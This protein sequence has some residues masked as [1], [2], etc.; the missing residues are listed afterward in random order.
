MNATHITDA[1]G[2]VK[3]SAKLAECSIQAVYQWRQ[4]GTIPVRSL[5]ML[6]AKKPGV[7]RKLAAEVEA[8][9]AAPL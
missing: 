5:A 1:L 8:S 2:G 7:F 6:K 3:A 9:K 4:A